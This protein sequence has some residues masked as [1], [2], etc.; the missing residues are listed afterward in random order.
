[1]LPYIYLSCISV[2]GTFCADSSGPPRGEPFS[3]VWM[4]RTPG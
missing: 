2:L 1:M 3:S 4:R